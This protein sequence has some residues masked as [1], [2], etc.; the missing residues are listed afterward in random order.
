M[1]EQLRAKLNQLP[2]EPGIYKMLN[3]KGEVIYIGKSKCLKKRVKSY[4][5][6]SPKWDKVKKMVLF[7]HDIEFIITDTHLEAMLLECELIKKEKPYFN[8]IMKNDDRYVYLK[9]NQRATIHPFSIVYQQQE[10]CFGPFRSKGRLQNVL[11]ALKNI[12]PVTMVKRSYDFEYHIIPV[13]MD[14]DT[15]GKNVEIFQKLFQNPKAMDRFTL[16][17]EK[18]MKGA[19]R[20]YKFE[21]ASMYR[22]LCTHINYL[23]NCL[24]GYADWMDKLILLH[25]PITEGYKLFLITH[26]YIIHKS[27]VVEITDLEKAQFLK[28]AQEKLKLAQKD[29]N[30]LKYNNKGSIDF[31]AIIYSELSTLPAEMLEIV[32]ENFEF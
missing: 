11:D 9:I 30:D 14:K 20:D 7:I 3:S 24:N 10:N 28:T 15:F 21:T 13:P 19:A 18:K 5:T 16:Q 27:T 2:S 32:K 4:F 29:L 31:S 22:D 12:Y 23:K 26:G 17:I 25:L 1:T 6:P 8:V